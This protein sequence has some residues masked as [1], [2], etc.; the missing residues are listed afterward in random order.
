MGVMKKWAKQQGFTIVEL[1]IVV[2]VIAILAAI[3]FVAFNGIQNR[4]YETTIQSDLSA[5]GKIITNYINEK[6]SVP[7]V[8]QFPGLGIRASKSAYLTSRN[9][10]YFCMNATTQDFA[11]VSI[12]K[13]GKSYKYINGSVSEIS[14]QPYGADTCALIGGSNPFGGYDQSGGTLWQ[15]WVN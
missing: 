9:N 15:T 3:T 8:A 7:F 1:L 4:A 12:T 2:V 6:G 5:N 14:G 10:M 11:M 13:S